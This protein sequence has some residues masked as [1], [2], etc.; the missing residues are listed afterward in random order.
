M[1]ATDRILPRA[2][3]C[4]GNS[5]A[6]LH[7]RLFGE[8]WWLVR[9][10]ECA[11]RY[12]WYAIATS[13]PTHQNVE[14][15]LAGTA[16]FPLLGELTPASGLL[17]AGTAAI[18][19]GLTTTVPADCR[20]SRVQ[21]TPYAQ[22]PNPFEHGQGELTHTTPIAGMDNLDDVRF[23][24]RCAATAGLIDPDS[25]EAQTHL[26]VLGPWDGA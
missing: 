12:H 9:A 5:N 6:G 19:L 3:R 25:Q 23:Y 26:R 10:R 22:M 15:S 24:V 21:D 20:W 2:G 16:T 1:T 13:A 4:T 11:D 14:R 17:P 18:T 7:W 8:Q